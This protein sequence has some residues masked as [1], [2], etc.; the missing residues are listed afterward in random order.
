M[1]KLRQVIIASFFLITATLSFSIQAADL[2]A[3][4]AADT[5]D[6]DIGKSVKKDFNNMRKQMQT[7]AKYTGLNLKEVLMEG[8]STNPQLFMQKINAVKANSDDVIVFYFGG[9]GY[10]TLS[11]GKSP[12]PNLVFSQ[13][14]KGIEYDLVIYNLMQ[15][16]PRFLITIADVCNSFIKDKNAPPLVTRAFRAAIPEDIIRS[17]YQQLFL[18]E[19]G[20]INVTSSQVGETSAGSDEEGGAYTS[21]FLISL[22]DETK[23]VST[24]K[25][26]TLLERA[27]TKVINDSTRGA[28]SKSDIQHPYYEMN[29]KNS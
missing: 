18:K 1:L 10:R 27:K 8:R 9:H 15:K 2:I 7:V 21:A 11:K 20:M 13:Q 14:D 25:W 4:I 26:R 3:I 6:Q 24:A 23:L 16:H 28:E 19:A 17:N 12:W 29:V 22:R 5:L